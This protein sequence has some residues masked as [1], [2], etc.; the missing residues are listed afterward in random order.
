MR[1]QIVASQ[2]AGESVERVAERLLDLDRPHVELPAHVEELRDAARF[3]LER[4]D[5]NLYERAVD[6]WQ[7]RIRRLGERQ[8][9]G[10]LAAG[11]TTMR[12]A[13]AQLVRDLRRARPEQLRTIVDRWVLDRARY[14]AR[15]VARTETVE[16]FRDGYRGAT[17]SQPYV[18]GYRW[19]LSNRHGKPDVCDV[20]ANQDLHGLGPG[21]YP[22][23]EV[24]S[25][26]HPLDLCSQVAI[27]DAQHFQRELARMRG[28]P[29][30]PRPWERGTRE[31]GA[32]WLARQS[33][34]DRVAILGPTRAR[35]FAERPG[36]VVTPD[37]HVRPVHAVLGR[38][39]PERSRGVRLRPDRSLLTRT[40]P[41]A[42]RLARGDRGTPAR[43][44]RR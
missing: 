34:A 21:G 24:P 6:R 18:K 41:P 29:E 3:A 8:A 23:D 25:T 2:R 31:T 13:T 35:V 19:T 4:G 11:S 15:V 12:S 33:E 32:E 16:A 26:P 43:A 38:P 27:V 20:L 36:R 40:L 1:R 28:Q 9:D 42:P 30:P 5:E 10:T 7:A 22:V 17:M 37:G 44:V 14:Q 39:T